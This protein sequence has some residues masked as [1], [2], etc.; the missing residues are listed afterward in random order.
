MF[1]N[2]INYFIS[3]HSRLYT[4]LILIY[5]VAFERNSNKFKSNGVAGN[6]NVLELSLIHI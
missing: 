4:N 2:S 5:D 6:I 1:L 3:R